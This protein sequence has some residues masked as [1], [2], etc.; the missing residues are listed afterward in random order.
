VELAPEPARG[1]A[2]VA[3]GV[4]ERGSDVPVPGEAERRE[5]AA[6]AVQAGTAVRGPVAPVEP[7]V[8][9]L[10][11][12]AVL[13]DLAAEAGVER[14]EERRPGARTSARR[15]E[16]SPPARATTARWAVVAEAK[17]LRRRRR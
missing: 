1:P 9:G 4:D 11:E 3:G 12:I 13:E 16:M 10:R 14:V 7:V 17:A 2:L 8:G 5:Q 6:E 15:E